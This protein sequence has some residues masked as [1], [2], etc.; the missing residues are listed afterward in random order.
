VT[1]DAVRPETSEAAQRVYK[2][3]SAAVIP[4]TRGQ[5]AGFFDGLEMI[6]PGLVDIN[7]WPASTIHSG[8][9][10]VFYGG[11]GI[12]PGASVRSRAAASSSDGQI[13]SQPETRCGSA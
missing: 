3:A 1:G 13:L 4:R 6:G 8:K 11:V 7:D 9:P 2:E 12:K 10:T 5:I